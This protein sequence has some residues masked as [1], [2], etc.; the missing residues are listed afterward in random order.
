MPHVHGKILYRKFGVLHKE[1]SLNVKDNSLLQDFE[2]TTEDVDEETGEVF[3]TQY[4]ITNPLNIY[5]KGV[6]IEI[7]LSNRA[8]VGVELL[9][10]Q[11]GREAVQYLNG[12]IKKNSNINI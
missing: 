5:A 12:L 3:H 2:E 9:Q 10:V 4:F 11:S 8:D 1:I 6:K 7:T